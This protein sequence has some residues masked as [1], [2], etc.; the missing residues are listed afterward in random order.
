MMPLGG[1]VS[2][3]LTRSHGP[4]FGRRVVVMAGL[5]LSAICTY[6]GTISQGTTAV[7]IFLS[8][9]FGFAA[10]CEG[11]F[12]A[13]LTDSGQSVGA[14]SSIL[15]TGAQVGGFFAP[16]ATP[17][18]AARWGWSWGL[19]VGSLFAILGIVAVYFV[20]S[21]GSLGVPLLRRSAGKGDMM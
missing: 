16:I 21:E 15:N 4:H 8:L 6:L 12:W 14:A 9:A 11:P 10:C 7:V 13:F 18:I 19:Y 17:Y 3:R 5:A 20:K 2:D 1:F